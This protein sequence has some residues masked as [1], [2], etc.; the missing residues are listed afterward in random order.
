MRRSELLGLPWRSVDL[1]G[2]QLSVAQTLV[3]YDHQPTLRPDT[4]TASSRRQIALDARTVAALRAHRKRQTEERLA[5]ASVYA[6]HGLVFAQPD[7]MPLNPHRFSRRFARLVKDADVPPL[8]L[9]DVR[10][11]H[12]SLMLQAGVHPK[13]VQE[14]LGHSSIAMTLDRYSHLVPSMQEEAADQLAALVFG[15]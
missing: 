4:K 9:R 11:T 13:I 12:A 3:F 2:G 6:T 10:H 15:V 8:I 5:V 14:R 7:G 1:D